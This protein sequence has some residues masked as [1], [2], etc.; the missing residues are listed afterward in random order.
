MGIT[1]KLIVSAGTAVLTAG[2]AIGLCAPAAQAAVG[3]CRSDPIV[4]LTNLKIL[5]LS[6]TVSDTSSDLKSVSYTLH[7]P[8]GVKPLLVIPTDGLVGQVEHFTYANDEPAGRYS[9]TVTA[10]TGSSVAVT[11]SALEVLLHSILGS[12]SAIG[13]SNHPITLNL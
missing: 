12:G 11:A 2:V 1:K 8:A 6:A 13:T 5:D 9:V 10:N 4:T 7:L 3:P